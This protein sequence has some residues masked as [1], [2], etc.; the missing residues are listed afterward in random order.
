M[1]ENIIQQ[2]MSE[3][4]PD[5]E[6]IIEKY[7]EGKD[8]AVLNTEMKE[9]SALLGASIVK[10]LIEDINRMLRESR[11]RREKGWYVV[12]DD[13]RSLLTS[14][15]DVCF[16]RTLFINHR[17]GERA[18]LADRMLCLSPRERMTEDA[19]A[20]MLKE[21][22]ETCYRKGGEASSILG[23]VSKETV[24]EKIHSVFQA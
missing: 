20:Q 21:A 3:M 23:S 2:A 9:Q 5:F 19:V 8:F 7:L 11:E 17:T 1:Y 24:K 22:V 18:Y 16:K 13:T 4:V 10:R 14:L 12:K 15:G 6:R